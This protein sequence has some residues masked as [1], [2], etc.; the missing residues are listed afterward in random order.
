MKYYLYFILV[1]I[2]G[3]F[4][5]FFNLGNNPPSL[6]WDEA[7]LGYNAL[8]I[9]NEGIDEHGEKFPLDRFIAFGDY[10]PP[11]Y[12]YSI[13]PFMVLLGKNDVAV[14]LPSAFAG[15]GMIV[16]TVILVNLLSGKRK[17]ALLSGLFI[18]VSPWS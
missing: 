15:I 14:R 12:I 13:V 1:I 11:G 16:F 7:S 2:L 6:Y 4:L 8:A 17:L 3:L 5:R 9:L 10:K 18:A